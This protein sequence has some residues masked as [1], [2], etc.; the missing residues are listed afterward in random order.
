M[1]AYRIGEMSKRLGLS[2]DTRRYY[3][4]IG[5][6]PAVANNSS[7]RSGAEAA[8]RFSQTSNIVE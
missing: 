6:L 2:V 5:L 4:K 8:R 3:E 7:G 1:S